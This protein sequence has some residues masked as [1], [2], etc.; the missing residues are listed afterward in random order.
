[1]ND[2]IFCACDPSIGDLFFLDNSSFYRTSHQYFGVISS[3]DGLCFYMYNLNNR[4]CLRFSLSSAGITKFI[5]VFNNFSN[6]YKPFLCIENS[7]HKIF[8]D[9]LLGNHA[10]EAVKTNEMDNNSNTQFQNKIITKLVVMRDNVVRQY[11]NTILGKDV[12]EFKL[13]EFMAILP[14]KYST[15]RFLKV[16]GAAHS[17]QDLIRFINNKI[18]LDMLSAKCM[19]NEA[20]E[21]Y[22]LFKTDKT[23]IFVN[24]FELAIPYFEAKLRCKDL[25]QFLAIKFAVIST[26]IQFNIKMSY[27]LFKVDKENQTWIPYE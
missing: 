15:L 22:V 24:S 13:S 19:N 1:M 4:I 10:D 26:C 16:N 6:G 21:F 20:I 25:P 23:Q 7:F 18:N 2:I 5:E 27:L 12:N 8:E 17:P 11:A 14:T 9:Y 3:I